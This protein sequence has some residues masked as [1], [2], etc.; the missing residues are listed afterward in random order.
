[1]MLFLTPGYAP[2]S[3]KK[4]WFLYSLFYKLPHSVWALLVIPPRYRMIY[5]FHVVCD[6][7]SHTG[8]WSIQPLYPM[9]L[10]IHGIWD[11]IDWA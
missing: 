2:W 3:V 10:T 4:D 9:N 11:P 1:M 7:V 5:V 8:K 6:I